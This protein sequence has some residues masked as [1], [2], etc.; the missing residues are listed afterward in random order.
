MVNA[1]LGKTWRGKK[2]KKIV[3]SE[4]GQFL[5][6]QVQQTKKKSLLML[7]SFWKFKITLVKY[8]TLQFG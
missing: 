7:W 3:D 5:T 8:V 2:E 4:R 1:K 6:S